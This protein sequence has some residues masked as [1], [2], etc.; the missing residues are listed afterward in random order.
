MRETVLRFGQLC[1][2]FYAHRFR[3]SDMLYSFHRNTYSSILRYTHSLSEGGGT[4]LAQLK[5][6]AL[7]ERLFLKRYPF[8]KFAPR[9][10]DPSAAAVTPLRTALKDCRV[11]LVSYAIGT[12]PCRLI[13]CEKCGSVVRSERLLPITIASWGPSFLP[14][15]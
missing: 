6:I 4:V 7:A 9:P 14:P 5:D 12:W 1:R 3:A 2:H 10:D 8:K 15:N 11:A 13:A